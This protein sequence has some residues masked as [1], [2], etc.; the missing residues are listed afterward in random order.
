MTTLRKP[1]TLAHVTHEAV[2]Q[3]GGIGTVLEGLMTSPVYKKHVKRSILIGPTGAWHGGEP[4]SR[5]GDAGTVLYSTVDKIDRANLGV[6]LRP[7]EWAFGVAFVYGKRTYNPPQ[8]GRNG[9][10]EVLLIDVSQVNR[11]RLALTKLRLWET[12]GIDSAKF[13]HGWDFEEYVRIAGP[14]FYALNALLGDSTDPC[15]IFSHEFMGICTALVAKMDDGQRFRTVYHAHECSTARKVLEDHD[16]HDVMFYNV[17]DRAVSDGQYIESVFPEVTHFFRH[18]LVSKTHLFDGIIA[19]GDRTRDELKFLNKELAEHKIDLVYNGVPAS[20]ETLALK[21]KSRKMLLDYSEALLGHR[22]D[23]LLTHVTRPVISKGLWRDLG[24]CHEL[25]TLLGKKKQTAVLYIL[26]SGGGVRSQQDVEHMEREYGWPRHHRVGHPDLCGPEVDLNH[27]IEPF[28]A[29]HKNVQVVL[30]NQFGW[31]PQRIGKRLPKGM[32]IADF[33]RATDVEFGMATYEPFGIS[34]LEPLGSGA[35]CVI[36]SVCG[37]MGFVQHVTGN[38]GAKNVIVADYIRGQDHHAV[39]TLKQIGRSQRDAVEKE[40]SREL[41]REIVKRLPR[42]D[43]QL[44]ALIA[45]GQKLV[46]KMGWDQVCQQELLPMLARI[47]AK[48]PQSGGKPRAI[49]T[50]KPRQAK[51]K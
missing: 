28:N 1:L 24:V 47:T 15:V 27:M 44:K 30:V 4:E 23:I 25:D 19:V 32:D 38:R 42:N 12:Y 50:A 39:D 5:L 26:T 21:K 22:P 49:R 18:V 8:Q 40:V 7:I 17:M 9:E 35:L 41:A 6:K 46:K 20:R 3:L 13:E 11:E 48:S 2:E 29:S 31:S 51:H 36:S 34:P 37:C 43:A 10:A 33:R 16:G 45:S 14:A